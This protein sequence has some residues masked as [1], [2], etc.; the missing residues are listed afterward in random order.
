MQLKKNRHSILKKNPNFTALDGDLSDLQFLES[1]FQKNKFDKICHL[2]AQAGVRYSAKNPHQYIQSNIVAFVNLLETLK[3]FKYQSFIYASSS[4]VYGNQAQFPFSEK[5]IINDPLSLYAA[6]KISNEILAKSY[7][8]FYGLKSCGLRFFTVYG[9]YGRPDMA[10]FKFTKSILENS[11]INLYN[12]GQ[13]ERDF[14][15]IDDIIAGILPVFNLNFDFETINLGNNHPESIQKLVTTLEKIIGK[16]AQINYLPLPPGEAKTTFANI[17]KAQKLLNFHPKTKI[18]TG[19][20]H[21][22]KWYQ[23][24]YL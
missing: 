17:T 23:S 3:N 21:F 20:K 12:N 18:E 13:M 7:Y 5:E 9:P 2:A 22:V 14:T 6:T 16:K 19:L 24:Y 11:E 10:Y 1:I 15:Y 4:S 8:N